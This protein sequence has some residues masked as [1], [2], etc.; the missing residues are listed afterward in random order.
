MRFRCGEEPVVPTIH[1][2]EDD[3]AGH[4]TLRIVNTEIGL[5]EEFVLAPKDGV[6]KEFDYY[7]RQIIFT[8][9]NKNYYCGYDDKPNSL[10]V[11]IKGH[12]TVSFKY[13][14]GVI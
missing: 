1:V 4:L 12:G 8:N 3:E 9:Y 11:Y 6:S 2:I 10:A 14:I 13:D 7:N 5:D